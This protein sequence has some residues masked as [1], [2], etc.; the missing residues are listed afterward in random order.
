[1]AAETATAEP[2]VKPAAVRIAHAAE[3]SISVGILILMSTLPL[4]EIAGREILGH[5]VPGSISLV[6]HLTLCLTFF[7]AALAAR[8]G[9]LLTMATPELLPEGARNWANIFTS[10]LASGIVVCL[11]LAAVDIVRVDQEAGRTIAWGIPVWAAVAVMPI[12]FG[13]IACRLIWNAP[14]G[15]TGRAVAATFGAAALALF[16]LVPVFAKSYLLTPALAVILI[17][18]ALGLPIFAAIGGAALVLFWAAGVNRMAV[19][20]EAY[21]LSAAEALPVIPLYTLGGYLLAE[22]GS[23]L[24]LMRT[25]QAVAGW[26]PGSL[27]IVSTLLLAFFTPLT[28]ASGVTILSMGGLIMPLMIK[29][30]YPQKSSIGLVTVAGSIGLLLPPSTPVILF[31]IYAHTPIPDLFVGAFIPGVLLIAA[32]AFWGARQ[33]LSAGVGRQPFSTREALSAIWSAKWDLLM[34]VVILAGIFGGYTAPVEAAAVTVLYAFIVEFLIHRDLKI[35]KDLPRICVEC[36]TLVGGFL[37]ILSVALGF[38]NY[39]DYADVPTRTLEWVQIHVHSPAVFLLALNLFL[40]LV[41]ALMDIYSAILVVVPLIIPVAAAYGIDPIHLGVIFL[42]N[43]ELGYLM[44]PMGENLFLS[45]Y[46]FHQPLGRIYLSTAP[47]LVIIL[48]VV[49]LITYLPVMTLAPV[50]WFR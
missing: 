21:R 19:P 28:G 7:G 11:L 34:P 24:R 8:S 41:G 1:M 47:F 38:T 31:A 50:S 14:G 10:G 26:V 32:I 18:T 33:G 40:I 13:L 39:L 3:S 25:F 49:L 35:I 29:A 2:A 16:V 42:A 17:A 9:R 12:G 48:V 22:G 23:G 27:A 20:E 6:Q 46:R 4:F 15:W 45:S 44:P 37:I 43:M 36:S 30:G 5:G